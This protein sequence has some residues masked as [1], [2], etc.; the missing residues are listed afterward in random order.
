MEV[1][2]RTNKLRDCFL[3]SKK[4]IKTYGDVVGKKYIQRIQIIKAVASLDDL[5]VQQPLRCHELKGNRKGQYA[6]NLTGQCRLIFTLEGETLNVV[7]IEEVSKHYD[8]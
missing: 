2:F 6:I 8:D 7:K 5:I 3:N 1:I 4:A